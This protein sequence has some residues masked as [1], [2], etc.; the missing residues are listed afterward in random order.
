MCITFAFIRVTH[1]KEY[2]SF[3]C[4]SKSS[5][6]LQ[7][8]RKKKPPI[9]WTYH[10]QGKI[11]RNPVSLKDG[12]AINDIH[13]AFAALDVCVCVCVCLFVDRHAAKHKTTNS[14]ISFAHIIF[15]TENKTTK[16]NPFPC[17]RSALN[18]LVSFCW[19]TKHI[20][21]FW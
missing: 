2:A 4:F 8:N 10:L 17:C 12:P 1:S 14:K 6:C 9:A 16:N 19:T 5:R 11:Q 3:L 7:Q 20:A 18:V 13:S 21:T 15:N